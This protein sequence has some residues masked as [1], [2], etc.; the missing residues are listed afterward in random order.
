MAGSNSLSRVFLIRIASSALCV[1]S[2]ASSTG[3]QPRSTCV[4]MQIVDKPPE[5]A[6][7]IFVVHASVRTFET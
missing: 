1:L 5:M 6:N 4:K 3:L 7:V 2:H